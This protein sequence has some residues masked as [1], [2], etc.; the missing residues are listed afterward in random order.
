MCTTRRSKATLTSDVGGVSEQ[1]RVLSTTDC[2][3]NTGPRKT[4]MRAMA[5]PPEAREGAEEKEEEEATV[6]VEAE[7]E[8]EVVAPQEGQRQPR[9][10]HRRCPHLHHRLGP[11]LQHHQPHRQ[12]P[13][14][15]D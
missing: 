13:H 9:L 3:L 14:Q 11:W 12:R 4:L 8:A 2:A 15:L 5:M 7:G 1:G 6:E 10:H